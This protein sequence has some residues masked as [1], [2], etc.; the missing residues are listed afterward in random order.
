MSQMQLRKRKRKE[1]EKRNKK[2]RGESDA[3]AH[4]RHGAQ[5]CHLPAW[6][7]T[8]GSSQQHQQLTSQHEMNTDC[9][10]VVVLLLMTVIQCLIVEMPVIR[11]HLRSLL[12]CEQV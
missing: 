6:N 5:P 2:T 7:L 11:N 10:C 1:K 12:A 3:A 4:V 8:N 9:A